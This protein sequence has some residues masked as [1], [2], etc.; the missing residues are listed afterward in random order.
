MERVLKLMDDEINIIEIVKSR[1]YFKNAMQFLLP[2]EKRLEFRER[3]DYLIVDPSDS[4]SNLG[5]SEAD[6]LD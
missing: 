1:R 3:G 6:F 2:R 4:D 5:N